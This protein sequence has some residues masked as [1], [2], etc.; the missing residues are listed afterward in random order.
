MPHKQKLL[1]LKQRHNMSQY[2]GRKVLS[3]A[4]EADLFIPG[5]GSIR[6]E[7]TSDANALTNAIKMTLEEPFVVL[8]CRRKDSGNIM[9]V[10]V[11]I[12]RFVYLVLDKQI[13]S[14]PKPL[15]E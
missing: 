7:L 9:V 1:Q 3:A 13:N 6:K 14:P 2:D 15:K 12:N 10:P 5:L 11:P 4:L 8:E